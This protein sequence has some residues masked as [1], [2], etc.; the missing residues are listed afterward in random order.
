MTVFSVVV[1][2]VVVVDIEALDD[3]LM[4]VD[5]GS[6]VLM[7]LVVVFGPVNLKCLLYLKEYTAFQ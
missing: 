3:L 5:A 1:G 7:V 2:V 4:E 6:G